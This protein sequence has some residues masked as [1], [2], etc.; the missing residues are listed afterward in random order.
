MDTSTQLAETLKTL[1]VARKAETLRR[2][3][4][5][6]PEW[7]FRNEACGPRD[8]DNLRHRVFYRLL[9]MA[10]LRRIRFHDP[11]EHLRQPS[12]R[13][14]RVASLHPRPAR[15]CLGQAHGG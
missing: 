15:A 5:S 11:S 1:R 6:V 2:G 9:E 4:G 12:D 3:W 8:G 10:G 14:G 7:V 13:T